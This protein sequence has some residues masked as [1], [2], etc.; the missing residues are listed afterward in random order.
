MHTSALKS[1]LDFKNNYLIDKNSEIKLVEIGSQSV[2][3]SIKKLLDKNHKYIGVD[4]VEGKNVDVVL[5]DPYKLPFKEDSVDVVISIST[6][7]HTEF[8]GLVT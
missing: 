4:I 3:E 5:D 1:F 2:N 8:F 6:F 7:E